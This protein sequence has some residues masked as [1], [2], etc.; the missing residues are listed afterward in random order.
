M[1]RALW[2]KSLVEARLLLVSLT[3]LMFGFQWVFI[4]IT[5]KVQ[6]GPLREFLQTLPVFF[7]NL[8]GIQFDIVATVM[9]RIAM[10]YIDP[11]VLV[12]AAIWGISR[13]SDVISG[14]INRGTMEMLLA[15]P[16][17]RLSLLVTHAS[18][19]IAGSV[20]LAAAALAG[21][22]V[23]IETVALDEPVS[24]ARF[25]PAVTNLWALIFFLAAT[26]TLVSSW[27]QYRW[28]TIGLMGGYYIISLVLQV[29]G[30]ADPQFEWM[31]YLSFLAAYE[32]QTLVTQPADAV[33]AAL[34]YNLVLVG[35]GVAAYVLAAIIFSRRDLPAPL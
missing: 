34:R 33:A 9:G 35:F 29:V 12:V 3:V 18:V 19:T 6:L 30:R 1:N 10:A 31:L 5:S 7:E 16:V 23:G 8:A 26:S 11:V 17:S 25:F 21:T 4:W 2:R 28:R 20:V 32:P 24:I 14:E 15:Q 13:G 27:D 22:W